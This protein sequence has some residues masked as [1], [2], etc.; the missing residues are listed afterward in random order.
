LILEL[1]DHA[2]FGLFGHRRASQQTIR[3]SSRIEPHK[4]VSVIEVFEQGHLRQG[5]RDQ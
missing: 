3:Q 2:S 4:D 5:V 1:R